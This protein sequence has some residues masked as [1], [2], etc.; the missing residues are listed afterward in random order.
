MAN[1]LIRCPNCQ[2]ELLLKNK[3]DG[4]QQITC[5]RC[6]F[7]GILSQFRLP[8]PPDRATTYIPARDQGLHLLRPGILKLC[9]GNCRP[10]MIILKK[11]INTIGRKIPGLDSGCSI[12]L[13]TDDEFMSRQHVLIEINERNDSTFEHHLS[14]M[15]ST[16][17]TS[18]DGKKLN[19]G[20]KIILRLNDK[21][22]IGHTSF[23]FIQD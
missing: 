19:R 5:P 23:I 21:I 1:V 16:N 10:E 12:P 3:I 7:K 17:G 2:A 6:N 11:G 8:P 18:L 13:E 20:D 15:G 22:R 4:N 9:E 14:D